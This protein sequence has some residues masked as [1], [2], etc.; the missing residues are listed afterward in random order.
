MQ[1]SSALHDLPSDVTLKLSDGSITAH[2][3]LL[4]AVSPVFKAMFYENF[5]E[6]NAR[7]VHL[8]TDTVKIMQML[9]NAV[10]K[11]SCEMD[12]V[13]DIIPLMEGVK[14]YQIEKKPLQQMCDEAIVTQIERDNHLDINV[15][16]KCADVMSEKSIRKVADMIMNC[17]KSNFTQLHLPWQ[18]LQLLLQRNDIA[19]LE[20]EIFRYL[21]KWHTQECHQSRPSQTTPD[22]FACIRYSL[23]PLQYLFAEVAKCDLVDKQQVHKAIEE[24][25]TSCAPL[26]ENGGIGCSQQMFDLYP[27]MPNYS[28]KIH[29]S[30]C[31]STRTDISLHSR[32]DEAKVKYS[33]GEESVRAILKSNALQNGIYSFAVIGFKE[34][35]S[36]SDKEMIGVK[37]TDSSSTLCMVPLSS[38]SIVTIS[39][40]D[41]KLFVKV[42]HGKLRRS[43]KSTVSATGLNPIK[44]IIVNLL[45]STA[46]YSW[47][48]DTCSF[49]IIPAHMLKVK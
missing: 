26:G 46:V 33:F 39:N 48:K 32:D 47:E 43:V 4:A 45:S 20:I 35:G 5:K 3:M 38:R 31:R 21:V 22:L 2:K 25:Y 12:S 10:F 17:A 7:E 34:E 9:L 24:I 23:I 11:G 6:A 44:V 13:Y 29:W 14:R 1:G 30:A 36:M 18:V 15:L 40:Q 41:G 28:L 8:P 42:I 49:T 16:S 19:C 37:F 27:R